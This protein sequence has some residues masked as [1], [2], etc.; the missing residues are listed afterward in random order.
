VGPSLTP[1]A[2]LAAWLA[3]GQDASLAT[4]TAVE[5]S[6]PEPAGS[7]MAIGPHGEMAGSVGGGCVDSALIEEARHPGSQ[8]RLL[9]YASIDGPWAAGPACG[10]RLTVLLEHVAP[11]QQHEWR[12]IQHDLQQD[13][14]VA[15]IR[16]LPGGESAVIRRLHESPDS[17]EW[18]GEPLSSILRDEVTA[19]LERMRAAADHAATAQAALIVSGSCQVVA[20]L[21]PS[22]PRLILAGADAIATHLTELAAAMG[23]AVTVCDPRPLFATKARFPQARQVVTAWPQNY[24][25]E[26]ASAGRIGPSTAV[27]VLTHDERIDLPTLTTALTGPPLSYLGAIGSRSTQEKRHRELLAAGIAPSTLARMH[28]PAGLDLQGSGPAAVALSILAELTAVRHGGSG[29]PLRDLNGRIHRNR[30]NM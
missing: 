1:I 7:M 6:G 14:T 28:G 3:A 4:L 25:H 18:S 16:V 23:Y 26:E 21:W 22:P 15:R 27:C 10:G 30:A 24:L 9:S 5:G 2:A 8:A 20:Q 12:L 29:R 13:E 19:A 17:W 11:E